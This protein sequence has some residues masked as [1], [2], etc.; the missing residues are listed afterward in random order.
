MDRNQGKNMNLNSRLSEIN[1]K[2]LE[3]LPPKLSVSSGESS[4]PTIE[5]DSNDDSELVIDQDW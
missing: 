1:K 5:D 2:L 4:Y 3:M